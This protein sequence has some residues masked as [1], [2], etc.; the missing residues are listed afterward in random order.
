MA[1]SDSSLMLEDDSIVSVYSQQA[2]HQSSDKEGRESGG[3]ARGENSWPDITA[4]NI[5][6]AERKPLLVA[7]ALK[8]MTL[9]T[10]SGSSSEL[11]VESTPTSLQPAQVKPSSRYTSRMLPLD[12]LV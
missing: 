11:S 4:E 10:T 12:R 1:M 9:G 6:S 8:N 5:E 2:H 3:G 7:E